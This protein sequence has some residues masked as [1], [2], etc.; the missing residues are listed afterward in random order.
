MS[1]LLA[2]AYVLYSAFESE[3][4]EKTKRQKKADF[5]LDGHAE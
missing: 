4:D 5:N 1:P 2:L 3:E